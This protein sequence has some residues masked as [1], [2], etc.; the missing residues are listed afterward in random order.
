MKRLIVVAIG[1]AVLAVAFPA[2][3]ASEEAEYEREGWAAL[4][5][6]QMEQSLLDRESVGIAE[7]VLLAQLGNP[8]Y[9]SGE[10]SES[11]FAHDHNFIAPPQ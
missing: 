8:S 6:K 10:E 5:R 4:E 11:P 7:T 2:A 1:S 3:Y 9:K